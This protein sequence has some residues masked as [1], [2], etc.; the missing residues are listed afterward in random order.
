MIHRISLAT[1]L[2]QEGAPAFR[3]ALALAVA[4]KSRLDILHVS[5]RGEQPAWENFPQVR[6]T[7]EAWGLLPPGSRQEDVEPLLGVGI[8]KVTIHGRDP[9]SGIA[10]F[11]A[12]HTPDLLVAASHGRAETGWWSGGSVAMEAMRLADLPS[13]LFGPLA[14][15][16]ADPATG[17]L[18]LRSVLMP[19]TETPPPRAALGRL[20]VLL[21]PRPLDLHPVHVVASARTEEEVRAVFPEAAR[22]EGEVV[23]ALLQAADRVAADVIAMPT[24]RHKGLLGALRGSTTEKVLRAAPCAVLALPS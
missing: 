16:M 19:V 12:K 13:L 21:D 11:V 5:S 2:S 8:T 18:A 3:A 4:C 20:H 6:S 7:L 22:L 24:A 1:D 9:A 17:A 15:E 23:P 14:R 10:D